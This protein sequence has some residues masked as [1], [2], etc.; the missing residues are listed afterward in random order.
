MKITKSFAYKTIPRIIL[1]PFDGIWRRKIKVDS[2]M[3]TV[4]E[5]TLSHFD[6]RFDEFL[7]DAS[8]KNLIRQFRNSEFLNWRYTNVP[9]RS[10]KTIITAGDDGRLNGYIIIGIAN[11]YGINVGF[12]MDLVTSEKGSDR[13]RGLIRSALEYFWNQNV[14]IAAALC[15]L[16]CIEYRILRE[17]GFFICPKWIRPNPFVLCMKPSTHNQDE[18]DGNILMDS[19]NWF[20]MFGDFQVF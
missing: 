6:N 20:F 12:I 8:T 15:F 7:K 4:E 5:Y 3:S 17:E 19:R 1:T 13:G 11:A 10:Y 16:N 2:N 18:V 14:A 9:G